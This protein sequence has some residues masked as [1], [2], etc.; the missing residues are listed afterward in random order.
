MSD[1]IKTADVATTRRLSCAHVAHD[2]RKRFEL[3]AKVLW[4][5][6]WQYQSSMTNLVLS[7][8][9]IPRHDS[10]I[11]DKLI[12]TR[13][14]NEGDVQKHQSSVISLYFDFISASTRPT[15]TPETK[16]N[17]NKNMQVNELTSHAQTDD[18]F[19]ALTFNITNKHD[20][21]LK[22]PYGVQSTAPEK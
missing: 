7:A 15:S 10:E 6:K 19:R 22:P 11:V 13:N 1:H 14:L 16:R 12:C 5:H 21:N 8:G 17:N 2:A 3:G 4:T 9:G 18:G 20:L